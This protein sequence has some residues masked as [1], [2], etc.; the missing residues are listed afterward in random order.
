MCEALVDL[1]RNDPDVILLGHR[2]Q[3]NFFLHV[4]RVSVEL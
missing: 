4:L 1:S 3:R 2:I